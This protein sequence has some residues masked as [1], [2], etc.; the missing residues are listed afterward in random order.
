MPFN[1]KGSPAQIAW[2]VFGGLD[3]E[4]APPTHPEGLSP[5]CQDV[6]FV[7]GSVFTRPGL[8]RVLTTGAFGTRSVNYNKT[9][10]Q[11]SQKPLNL[12]LAGDGTFAT[13]DVAAGGS[14]QTLFSTVA[15]SYASSVTAF[16]R[17]YI[18]IHDGQMATDIPRQYDPDLV[19]NS[20]WRRLTQD[21]PASTG[22]QLSASDAPSTSVNIDRGA[23]FSEPDGIV[24][25][26][27]S[28][29]ITSATNVSQVVTITT[30]A[31]H[32][33]SVG[34]IVV[35]YGVTPFE[36]NGT[37]TVTAVPTSNSFTYDVGAAFGNGTSFGTAVPVK[38][39][40]TTQTPHGLISGETIVI[41]GNSN[42]SYN[43]S[44]TPGIGLMAGTRCK[45][46]PYT[47]FSGAFPFLH[48]SLPG[49]TGS[50]SLAGN[51]SIMFNP[52]LRDGTSL[53]SGVP[54]DTED[55]SPMR[56]YGV[57]SLGAYDG[58]NQSIGGQAVPSF[59]MT[60]TGNLSIPSAGTFFFRLG[61]DDGAFM[62]IG[63]GAQLVN[64][65]FV[66][67][68]G[69]GFG[70]V[71]TAEQG[72]SFTGA[73]SVHPLVGTNT[74]TDFSHVPYFLETFSVSFPAAGIYPFE[75]DYQ[76]WQ[77]AQFLTLQYSTDGSTW[78]TIL[79][80]VPAFATPP[81]WTV[82]NVLSPTSFTF[83]S[84]FAGAIGEGGTVT[85]GGLTAPGTHQLCVSFLTDT[86][87]ITKPSPI[88]TWVGS[89]AKKVLVSGLPIGPPNVVARIVHFTGSGGGNFFYLPVPA[90][91]PTSGATVATSTV[92]NDNTS[93]TATFD[94]SDNTLFNG[95]AVDVTGNNLF[96]QITLGPCAGVFSYSNRLV[97]WGDTNKINN[98]LNMGFE[99]GT[100][101]VGGS[102]PLGW[103]T[104]QNS[105][106][107]LVSAGDFYLGWQITGNGLNV[108]RGLIQQPAYQDS[109]HIP[110]LT[111]N[112]Q[113]TFKCW[114]YA[115]A[116][117]LNGSIVADLYSPTSGVLATATIAANTLGVGQSNGKFV[118]AD[119]N[120]LTPATIPSDTVLRV[121]AT[122]INNNESVTL[123]EMMLIFTNNPVILGQARVSYAI[124][125]EAFDGVT[126]IYAVE[127]S[128]L[129]MQ[130]KIIRDNLYTLTVGHLVRTTD[131]GLGEPVTWTNY[132]VSD[133][134]GGMSLR[135]FDVAEG[136]GMFAAESGLY[137]FSG[138]HPEKV[139][140][141]IQTLWD[142]IDPNLRKHVWVTNDPINRRIYVGVPLTL[143]S[144]T[145]ATFA[146]A[147]CNK[148]L[149]L[150]YRN[151]NTAEAIQGQGPVRISFSG[152]LIAT[153]FARKWTV[154]NIPANH[155]AIMS[156]S[157]D[158][159]PQ[160]VFAGG[161]GAGTT[162]GF[163]N[164]YQL[165]EDYGYDEDYGTIG[166]RNGENKVR[167]DGTWRPAQA[168][169][170]TYF[171]PSHEQE[172]AFQTGN[173]RKLFTHLS[174][175]VAGV[176]FVYVVPLLD[177]L[178][179]NSTRP[180]RGRQ[181]S[182]D[183]GFD[184]DWPLNIQTNRMALLIYSKSE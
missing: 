29:S 142:A 174:G 53:L 124:N 94:F 164:S 36:Y 157:G 40:V 9:F 63:G 61:H 24:P 112:T 22:A 99:G 120:A 39:T 98:L 59:N 60:V 162:R 44:Q 46:Y 172:Y 5:D 51:H 28:V 139:S 182:S 149:V 144:P 42:N 119:F 123:D 10:I 7:P 65:T 161:D 68:G 135:C 177:R 21:G 178:S 147:S 107:A 70:H 138:G 115:S 129:I 151:L 62:A 77:S 125:P 74:S 26:G 69:A 111:P 93:T 67:G 84:V 165:V 17:E 45:F 30:A 155:G 131:N 102:L 73:G 31:A 52:T 159:E 91:D 20:K 173:A 4:F 181:L 18:A 76:N 136:W 14:P 110:I 72:L 95:I 167:P 6:A 105:G 128:E 57:N 183:L 66:D 80:G 130:M 85:L 104:S 56:I 54:A 134:A 12:F 109:F 97:V 34:D 15:G 141:E 41:A 50:F 143:Y 179:R 81:T 158:A 166:G 78:K 3:T 175:Y 64:G 108:S 90:F 100:A 170:V 23:A 103:D 79:P 133:I 92:V 19:G 184:L 33:L 132:T 122:N 48:G 114:A 55:I 13:Q 101:T 116:F 145:G 171:A 118:S 32:G 87:Y 140:Q 137:A 2:S 113:Y 88:V 176:G 58:T 106:G 96:N 49:S 154:W 47:G 11:P 43:N 146:P 117:N 82:L 27:S 38:A 163:G 160:I 150:D 8:K 1:P 152:K 168:Y 126:G 37:Y 180:P 153:D 35:I 75:I 127:Y 71:V 16:G 86:G 148:M 83:N 121:Y 89:G 169:Y 25:S 156:L